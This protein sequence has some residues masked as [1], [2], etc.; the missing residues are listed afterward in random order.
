LIHAG[1]WDDDP[2]V[3][4]GAAVALWKLDDHKNPLVVHVLT[5]ALDDANELICWVAVDCLGQM[6]PA[7]HEAV[8]ALRRLLQKDF[9]IS[10][11]KRAATLALERIDPQ[12][13]AEAE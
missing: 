13:Q 6:G 9:R 11:I 3:R 12:A 8:P 7:A 10:L 4:V 1:L 2:A 5:K